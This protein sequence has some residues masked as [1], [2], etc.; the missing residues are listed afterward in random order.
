MIRQMLRSQ[1]RAITVTG[2]GE[3]DGDDSR[4][5]TG[6]LVGAQDSFVESTPPRAVG[7]SSVNCL[8]ACLD[9][10]LVHSR[11]CL[12]PTSKLY[13]PSHLMFEICMEH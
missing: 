1:N 12:V 5:G 13:L 8:R 2:E 3:A 6:C 10:L 4:K 9:I 11:G 7:V